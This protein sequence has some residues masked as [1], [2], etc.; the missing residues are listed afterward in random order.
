MLY[1]DTYQFSTIFIADINKNLIN[2]NF[3]TCTEIK[4]NK[5]ELFIGILLRRI[6]C[7]YVYNIASKTAD[8]H[9]DVF[10]SYISY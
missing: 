7:R 10:I 2:K 1:Y 9:D 4:V 8:S 3:K 6:I 5:K